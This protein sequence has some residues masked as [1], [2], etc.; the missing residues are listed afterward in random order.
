MRKLITIV[1]PIALAVTLTLSS[2]VLAK[3]ENGHDAHRMAK[4]L[5]QLSLSE[6]QKQDIKQIFKQSREDRRAL[7]PNGSTSKRN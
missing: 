6:T 1:T 4:V 5:S 7:G 3:P 2:Q